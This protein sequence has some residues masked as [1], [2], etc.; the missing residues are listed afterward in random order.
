VKRASSDGTHRALHHLARLY[1]VQTG[2]RGT[3]GK[4]HVAD[5]EV[6]VAVL[7]ALGATLA[8]RQDAPEALRAAHEEAHRRVVEPVIAHRVGG[9]VTTVVSL[10]ADVDPNGVWVTLAHEDGQTERR[11]LATPTGR[12]AVVRA[13]ATGTDNTG[14]STCQ[15]GFRLR[16]AGLAPGYHRLVV[17]GPGIDAT[18]L[19]VSAPVRLPSVRRQWGL[20]VPLYAL[21]TRADW[22]VGT[23][24]DLASFASWAGDMG[25]G[26]V[27]TLP[28][29]ATFLEGPG[30]DPSPYLPASRLAWNEVYVDVE[31]L[32]E[33]DLLPDVRSQLRGPELRDQ[34]FRLRRSPVAHPAATLALKRRF[35]EPMA[36]ALVREDARR[37][38]RRAAW[39]RWVQSH[40]ETVAYACFRSARERLGSSWR[41]W[42]AHELT[43]LRALVSGEE[44]WWRTLAWDASAAYHLYT[45][46]VSDTQIAAAADGTGGR[47]RLYLDLPVGVHADGF[48]AFMAP[49]AFVTGLTAGAPPDSFFARGQT[50]GFPPLHPEGDRAQ[51]YPYFT[52]VLR[53]AM[54]HAAAVR[55]D[56]VMGLH[57]MY[58][59][60]PGGDAA[61]GVYLSYRADELHALLVLEAHRSGT[62][63]A[64]E[65][66][67]TVPTAVERA[68]ARDRMLSSHVLQFESTGRDPLP[69]APRRSVATFATHDLPPFAGYWQGRDIG[70]QRRH[71]LLSPEAADHA[72]DERERWRTSVLAALPARGLSV[73][74]HDG[75]A[76][77]ERRALRGCLGHLAAGQADVFLV[78]LEDL[79]LESE[80]Q[81]RP[82]TGPEAANFRRRAA[83]T[84][85]DVVAD[86]EIAVLLREIDARRRPELEGPVPDRDRE[87]GDGPHHDASVHPSGQAAAD[88]PT[89]SSPPTSLSGALPAASAPIP[90][91]QWKGAQ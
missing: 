21:R 86:A 82:G 71:D 10:P 36:Q 60:P 70:D 84:L 18:A 55:L 67:G 78:D 53:T 9:S 64:G 23:F 59:V 14:S 69:P 8:R 33:I 81:N 28:L 45:Q 76:A 25:A 4:R 54:R 66:L 61:Q 35:L 31:S 13:P 40:P 91:T 22:G 41:Q 74:P 85:E 63:V 88:P 62:I 1:G 30:A 37:S 50:W 15:Y 90:P 20:T 57:R 47:A 89:S 51:G 75:A 77:E 26:L 48:D 6:L 12:R 39:E 16:R 49:D 7:G 65:D 73:L 43:A 58:V 5:D 79:W 56:H 87:R 17:E 52:A 42:P 72:R 38:H 34:L 44:Q 27:G 19:V 32:P 11:R 83:R 80:P 3:D 24:G 29:F 46:W 68:M 2:F